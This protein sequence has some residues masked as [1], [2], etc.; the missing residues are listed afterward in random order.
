MAAAISRLHQKGNVVKDLVRS[1]LMQFA[2]LGFLSEPKST[3][4][5][6][7]YA[8]LPAYFDGGPRPQSRVCVLS[9]RGLTDAIPQGTM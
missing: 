8:P 1:S 7:P 9:K 6:L 4:A 2:F 5:F 3:G